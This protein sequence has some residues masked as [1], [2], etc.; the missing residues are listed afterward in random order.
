MTVGEY[1]DGRPGELFIRVSKQ[2]S[3]LAGIMDAFAISVSHG[4]QY[5]VPL[6]AFVEAF[7]GMRFEP[8][9]MTDDPEVRIASSLMDYL[10]RRLALE[11]LTPEERQPDGDPV[12]L[13]A[14]AADAARRR[15]GDDD[16]GAGPRHG[17]RSALTS[18]DPDAHAGADTRTGRERAAVHAVR[19]RDA[20][21]RLLLRLRPVR[22]DLRLLVM[23]I[24]I[25]IIGAA[26][27]RLPWLA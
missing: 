10:F 27:I 5:G 21:R 24:V 13:R 26:Q 18:R 20:A 17:A 9:G 12:G 8:A 22:S 6:R 11:Y 19:R 14:P 15:G 3:T 4:L 7:V 23:Q 1:D 25:M 2:G 16:H